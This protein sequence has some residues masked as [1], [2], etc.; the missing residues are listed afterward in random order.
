[1]QL[2]YAVVHELVKEIGTQIGTPEAK[3]VWAEA[4]LST[5]NRVVADLVAQIVGLIGQGE[6]MAHYGVFRDDAASTRVP[7][8][9]E[10]LLYGGRANSR[11]FSG[12]DERL[13]DCALRQ[14][15]ITKLGHRRLFVIRRL[16]Q[17]G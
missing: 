9:S 1:M 14:G 17:H 10:E 8:H 4:L 11:R 13:Y 2:N 3:V 5:E 7:R 6:N 12:T 16:C 15:W